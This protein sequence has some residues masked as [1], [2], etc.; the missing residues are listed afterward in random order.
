MFAD[1][2]R[3]TSSTATSAWN[4]LESPAGETY[5]WD[6][7]STYIQE[8]PFFE[9]L[10][11]ASRGAI[12]PIRGARC[13]ASL[14]DSVTTDHISPAGDIPA[15]GPAGAWLERAGRPEAPTSTR[16]APGAATTAS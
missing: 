5:P 2:V 9:G 4:A 13:L 10:D 1:A 7:K 3:A 8:P 11:A 12:P 15:E 14:G 16:S 6:A